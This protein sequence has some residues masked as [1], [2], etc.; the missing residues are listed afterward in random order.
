M[1][2][3]IEDREAMKA[4]MIELAAEMKIPET[5]VTIWEDDD[6]AFSVGFDYKDMLAVGI[7]LGFQNGVETAFSASYQDL[8]IPT[9]GWEDCDTI[10]EAVNVV[11]GWCEYAEQNYREN[12][13]W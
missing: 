5:E 11:E 10:K 13:K 8:Q 7:D 6:E 12:N 2:K 3:R 9:D 1:K 4:A